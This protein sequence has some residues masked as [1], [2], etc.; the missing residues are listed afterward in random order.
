MSDP[1]FFFSDLSLSAANRTFE[2]KGEKKLDGSERGGSGAGGE[3][4]GGQTGFGPK[5]S[6]AA[7]LCR[8]PRMPYSSTTHTDTRAEPQLTREGRANERA[9][10]AHK[11]KPQRR[12]AVVSFA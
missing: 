8:S 1:L 12:L 2:R 5:G 9:F 4:E 11:K 7:L 3:K 10:H 6:S